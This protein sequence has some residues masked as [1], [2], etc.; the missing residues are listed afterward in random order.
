MEA[1][2]LG[3]Y[4]KVGM[5]AGILNARPSGRINRCWR[6]FEDKSCMPARPRS[7]SRDGDRHSS[8]N[9]S[10]RSDGSSQAVAQAVTDGL[11]RR[12]D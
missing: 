12:I 8:L 10:V 1:H 5:A 6:V 9:H 11:T 4:S 2:L 7:I 3:I